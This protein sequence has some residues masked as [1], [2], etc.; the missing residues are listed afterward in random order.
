LGGHFAEDL[1]IDEQLAKSY[2]L[3]IGDS[4]ELTEEISAGVSLSF[5]E[6]VSTVEATVR[7]I[8][9]RKS[10]NLVLSDVIAK[11]LALLKTD[12]V[13]FFAEIDCSGRI[14]KRIGQTAFLRN[15][16]KFGF[17]QNIRQ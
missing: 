13:L 15:E 4:L 5:L 6:A 14:G 16:V 3:I 10:E 11:Y 17:L 9:A 1:E 8:F 2:V 12:N 7:G